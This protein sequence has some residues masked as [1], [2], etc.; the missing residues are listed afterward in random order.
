MTKGTGQPNRDQWITAQ[1]GAREHYAVPRALHRR[2][3]LTQL[4]TDAW[5]KRGRSIL[6]QLPDPFR[7]FANRYH[8]E[9]PRA[10]VTSHTGAAVW[11]RIKERVFRSIGGKGQYQY[12]VDVGRAFARRVREG[13]RQFGGDASRSVFFGYDTGSL[14]VLTA[15]EGTDWF[16]IV[17]QMD[18]GALEKE[19]VQREAERWPGWA[20]N[21]PVLHDRYIERRQNEWKRASAVVVNS[22]WS[23]RALV[24]QDVPNEK[25]H[26][27]PLAYETPD[28]EEGG[29]QHVPDARP[30]RVLWLGQVGLR[31]GIQYL[32]EAARELTEASVQFT[33]VGPLQITE[34]AVHA[35]P[36]NMTFHGRVPRD[37]VGAYYKRADVFVLPTL[38]DGFAI[39]QLEAMAHGLP[40]IATPNCGRVVRDG[41]NGFVVS[42]RD[43]DALVESI[44]ELASTQ[45]RLHTMST[46]A[47]E[48]VQQYTI[49]RV[50]EELTAVVEEG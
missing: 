50:A 24:E 45:E 2:G 28:G 13:I 18:P 44:I 17:D 35:A 38:S 25:I 27:V 6:R 33:V 49:D 14:E 11:R 5:C 3:M 4:Y 37:Q 26:V 1:I 30:L 8:S 46:Q 15:L 12:Y 7:S 42:P 19:I 20:A 32:V 41:K 16:T 48:T 29:Q 9:L 10:A 23:K 36:P 22:E 34:Q 31:K 47:L 39:T 43:S 21:V 40:V